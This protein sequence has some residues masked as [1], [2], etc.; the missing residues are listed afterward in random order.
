MKPTKGAD[1]G[2]DLRAQPSGWLAS[3][4]GCKHI[5]DLRAISAFEGV[6][7]AGVSTSDGLGPQI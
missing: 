6:K 1:R 7:G 4:R 3:Q 2:H 5:P